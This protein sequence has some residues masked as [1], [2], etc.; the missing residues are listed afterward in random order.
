MESST[1]GMQLY[2]KPE[3][4]VTLTWLPS[5]VVPNYLFT[6]PED[7]R[8][9]IQLFQMTDSAW[10]RWAPI[11]G[12]HMN[13]LENSG[14]VQFAIPRN[15]EI[16]SC[17]DQRIV[18]PVA[19]YVSAVV[20]TSV[21]VFGEDEVALLSGTR[22]PGTGIWSSIAYLQ[23]AGVNETDL[24]LVCLGW[25]NPPPPGDS[26]RNTIVHSKLTDLPACPP[27][28]SQAVVD[29]RYRREVLDSG[30]TGHVT[31]YA[32]AANRFY[33]PKAAVCY[34]EVAVEIR[35]EIIMF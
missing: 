11:E 1:A 17:I 5:E 26:M 25:A 7:I 22:T 12:L 4:V 28:L 31:G 9:N 6:S 3:D 29:T 27:L 21:R 33:S 2:F 8:I 23:A 10:Q 35:S 14:R 13:N 15:V 16:Q 30:F 19:F 18:C 24:N 32:E 34:L 20:G